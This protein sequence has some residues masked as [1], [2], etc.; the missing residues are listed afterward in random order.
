MICTLYLDGARLGYALVTEGTDITLPF[1]AENTDVFYIGGQGGG[2]V[3][4]AV[5]VPR[6][7]ILSISPP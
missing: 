5:V 3:R 6:K 4:E 7:G 1:I 2:F